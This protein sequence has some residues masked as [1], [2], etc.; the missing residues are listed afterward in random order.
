MPESKRLQLCFFIFSF[1]IIPSISMVFY[2]N[3]HTF[4]FLPPSP[5]FPPFFPYL[6]LFFSPFLFMSSLSLSVCLSLLSRKS[7]RSPV[8]G[9][10]LRYILL[11]IIQKYGAL[12]ISVMAAL[13]IGCAHHF[14]LGFGLNNKSQGCQVLRLI[15]L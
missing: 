14:S 9:F 10:S 15:Q 13:R 5:L 8:F 1:N 12:F 6:L 2:L 11:L 4:L 7:F 3:L